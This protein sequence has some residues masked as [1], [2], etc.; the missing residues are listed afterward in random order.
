M[1]YDLETLTKL[2]N[3]IDS[4]L[5]EQFEKYVGLN[6]RDTILDK[7]EHINRAATITKMIAPGNKMAEV[8]AK[9]HDIGRFKQAE[10][11]NTFSDK[12]SGINHAEYSINVLY[13]DNL[14]EKF[15]VDSKYN[16]IIKKAVLNHNKSAIETG[17][18]EEELL[19]AKIIRDADKLDIITHVIT[20][21]DFES[22]FWYKEFNCDK[23]NEE[24]IKI[25]FENH[26]LD[27]AKIKNNADQILSFYD[28]IFD[29]NFKA[30][31][32]ELLSNNALDIFT[33][34]IYEKFDSK[35]IKE[36]TKEVFEYTQNYMKQNI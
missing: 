25:M 12:E 30:S 26:T 7:I 16:H 3:F 15:K 9:F 34:R 5:K 32:Q 17:L 2:D 29:L 6:G 19:F 24:L 33:N 1:R 31:L 10:K 18:S 13:E 28:M 35:K 21:Y 14:I 23:I 36:Q 4:Y 11:Y 22:V 8:A 27:Y 20:E